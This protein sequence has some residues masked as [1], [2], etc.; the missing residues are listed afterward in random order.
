MLCKHLRRKNS[1]EV[2]GSCVMDAMVLSQGVQL[3][4]YITFLHFG[5]K[6]LQMVSFAK[7]VMCYFSF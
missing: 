2:L 7:C 3:C 1:I 6:K 5:K 4:F